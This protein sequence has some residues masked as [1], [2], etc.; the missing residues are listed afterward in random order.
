MIRAEKLL[1]RQGRNRKPQRSAGSEATEHRTG[2]DFSV[3]ALG[4]TSWQ[5]DQREG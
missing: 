5:T 3:A 2:E 1:S 4:G